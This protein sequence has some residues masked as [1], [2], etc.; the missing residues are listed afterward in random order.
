MRK[1]INWVALMGV[2]SLLGITACSKKDWVCRCEQTW[3]QACGGFSFT[4][5][6]TIEN[7][8]DKDAQA[9]CNRL[10]DEIGRDECVNKVACDLLEVK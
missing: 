7:Q 4:D 10:E 8:P 3:T 9:I 1:K 2:V 5:V 6:Y